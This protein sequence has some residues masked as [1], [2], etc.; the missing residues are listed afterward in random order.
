MLAALNAFD[1]S[2][3]TTV[4]SSFSTSSAQKASD[5]NDAIAVKLNEMSVTVQEPRDA[6][7]LAIHALLLEAG[8]G[9]TFDAS[10]DMMQHAT[11][12]CCC[13]Y[14]LSSGYGLRV[15]TAGELGCPECKWTFHS[16]IRS[17]ER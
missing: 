3:S 15:G 7:F 2:P 1:P 5:A 12:D 9:G 4:A 11:D 10:M 8:S 13:M 17:S 14:R 16:R 6:L